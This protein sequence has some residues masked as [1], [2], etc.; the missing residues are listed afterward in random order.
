MALN[1]GVNVLEV[2][3]LASPALERAPTSVGAFAGLTERG[4]PGRAQRVSSTAQFLARFGRIRADGFLGYAID[5]F[6]RNGGREAYVVRVVGAGSTS[7]RADLDDRQPTAAPTLRIE[8]GQRGEP[9]PGPWGTRLRLDVRDDPRARTGLS[10]AAPPNATE[11]RLSSLDGIREGSVVRFVDGGTTFYRLVTRVHAGPGRIEW[12]SA[13]PIVPGLGATT[14]VTTAEFRIVV[15]YQPRASADFETVE[16][17]RHLAMESES[18]DYAVSRINHEQTG[19]RYVTATVLGGAAP[20]GVRLPVVASSVPLQSGTEVAPTPANFQQGLHG[21]DTHRVQLLGVPDAHAFPTV[22]GA[23]EQIVRH[24]LDYCESSVRGDC[25]FVG[26]APDRGAPAG[27]TPTSAGD[28]SEL[29]S[30]YVNTVKGYA[31]TFHGRKVFGALYAPWIRVGDPAGTGPAPVRFVPV[32]GHVMGVYARTERARGIHKAPAGTAA[33]VRGSLGV[34][35][36]FTDAQHT[37]LVRNGLVNGV[38]RSPGAGIIVA[39][40]RTLSSDTRWWFVNVRLLFN[41]VKSSLRDGLR[42]VRQEPHTEDLRK[43]VRL[44]VVRP[45]LLG[46]WRQGAFGSDPADDVFTIV[47]G[48]ENNPPD[49]VSLG[50]F[51]IEVYFYPARPA[52][53]ILI[54]VGQQ[55]SG[56]TASEG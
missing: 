56:A 3:G 38:R 39:A 14:Q 35:A 22:P 53:T 9:D 54:T 28:Y 24:A 6:F 41:F 31:A 18:P 23:R 34:A 25:M 33:R 43:A 20:I 2:D 40:S 13:A 7:A 46:L 52:E 42:F 5:G 48:P 36:D 19:S 21:F 30:D 8:A 50:R 44:N 10:V 51:K 47:C 37:D 55:P 27:V 1:V 16:E 45:F 4:V 32:E 12:D 17:W 29:E 26:S 11:A 49:Q 15:R